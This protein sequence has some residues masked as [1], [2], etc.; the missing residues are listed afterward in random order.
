[1]FFLGSRYS[2]LVK[3]P[4]DDPVVSVKLPVE[5]VG[6]TKGKKNLL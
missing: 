4:V 1:M 3:D 6:E 5:L 2:P